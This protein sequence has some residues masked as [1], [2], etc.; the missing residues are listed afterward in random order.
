MGALSKLLKVGIKAAERAA[1][2]AAEKDAAKLAV[3]KVAKKALPAPEKRLALPAPD[4]ARDNTYATLSRKQTKPQGG[5]WV[6]DATLAEGNNSPERAVRQFVEAHR[7][8]RDDPITPWLE[9]ALT[10]YVKRDF[11]SDADPLLSLADRGMLQ[12]VDNA[13]HWRMHSSDMIGM[14]AAG[15][16][17][18]LQQLY[19]LSPADASSMRRTDDFLRDVNETM[20][21]VHKMP[22]T[23]P[24]YLM[25]GTNPLGTEPFNHAVDELRNAM[26]PGAGLPENLA[27]RP[28]MLQRMSFPQA[29]ERTGM[30]NKWRA[31]QMEAERANIVASNPAFAVH[32]EYPDDPRGLRWMQIK[33]PGEL[34]YDDGGNIPGYDDLAAAL[35]NEGDAM[36]HCVGGYCHDVASGDSG[37]YTLR[38]AKGEPHVTIETSPAD[39]VYSDVAKRVGAEQASQWL[40]EGLTL[41]DMLERAGGREALGLP[42][43][44]IVQIKGKQNA[45]P[46]DDYIPYVRDFLKSRKWSQIGDAGNANLAQ[47]PDGRYVTRE[48]KTSA[49]ARRAREQGY[50][51]EGLEAELN[52][53]P[54]GQMDPDR[55]D[56]YAPYFEG[57]ERFKRGGFVVKRKADAAP[58]VPGNIDLHARP[59]VKNADGSI[60]TVRSISIGTDQGEV[61]IP[62]VSDDGRIMGNEE[63]VDTYRRTGK[64]LGVFKTPEEAT[65]YARSLH[66]A[67][68]AEYVGAAKHKRGGFVVKRNAACDCG[69]NGFAVKGARK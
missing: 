67:Q 5:Q 68:A 3:K 52:R 12:G 23:D 11:N 57:L 62:T 35:K 45:K 48:D 38:D 41:R 63:A 56:Q 59:V 2:R 43:D 37:I 54:A 25:Y 28:E 40:D 13:E 24:V 8:G 20:P 21:W 61:L 36:G 17:Q 29:V 34:T 47:L 10:K 26:A 1:P 9:K 42:D 33:L 32:K 31:A 64:H 22:S 53:G 18:G 15:E 44:S 16:Y 51:R 6:P 55:W 65:T 39:F 60:S 58:L 27:V 49:L 4:P 30:I 19:G 14:D 50:Y 46:V 66:D 7:V 69:C